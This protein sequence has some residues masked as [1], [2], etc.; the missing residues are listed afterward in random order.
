MKKPTIDENR[1]CPKCGKVENQIRVGYNDS[2][3]QRCKCKECNLRY[4]VNSQRKWVYQL[5]H[6]S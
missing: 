4:T 5:A 1:R 3:T 2:G 6:L